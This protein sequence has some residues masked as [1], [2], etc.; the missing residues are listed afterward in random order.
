MARPE[1]SLRASEGSSA[2]EFAYADVTGHDVR[3]RHLGTGELR[4]LHPSPD[5]EAP[6]GPSRVPTAVVRHVRSDWALAT[7]D[8]TL[9]A[10]SWLTA[11]V[12]KFDA[13]GLDQAWELSWP[14]LPLVVLVTLSLHAAVGLYSGVWRHAS[15]HEARRVVVAHLLTLAIAV[16]AVVLLGRR[17]G[18]AVPFIATGLA[19]GLV[20][21][22]RF[23]SRLFAFRRRQARDAT[24]LIVLGAGS[25]GASLARD[26][27]QHDEAM[28]TA[29][30]DDDPALNGRRVQRITVQGTLADLPAVARRTGATHAVLAIPSAS[31]E[32]V[33]RVA[34][35][36]EDA[37]VVLRVVPPVSELVNG[38]VVLR[39]VRDLEIS[40]LLSRAPVETD[41]EDVLGLVRGRRVLVTGGGGSIGSEIARQVAHLGAARVVLV[42][43]DET[44]LF[45]TAAGLPDSA[46]LRL[47]DIREPEALRRLFEDE[48]PQVV[49][50]AAAHKHVP[51]LETHPVE[52]A[53]T[54]VLGTQSVV[55]AAHRAGVER[56]VF[57]S[58][59]KAVRPKSLMG[60]T[61]LVGERV[62]LS[63]DNAMTC[64]AVRFGNVLGS[65]G[66]VV[67]TFVQ[68]IRT[69]GPVTI[70]DPRMTRYF[71]SIPEAVRLVLHAAALSRG[72]EIFMLD[73]GDPVSVMDL[74][75]RMI[76]LSG[77]R[78]GHDIEVRV[79][80]IRPGEKLNEQLHA[81]EEKTHT[82]SHP[83]IVRLDPVPVGVAAL[84]RLL[85]ELAAAA[86]RRDDV[87]V[88]AILRD[89]V[90]PG[91]EPR[92]PE[93]RPLEPRHARSV[94]WTLSA[95]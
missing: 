55:E 83:A 63:R 45:D 65:R 48:R 67:P 37:G 20:G 59:D 64:C 90:G 4:E 6:L 3:E 18:I 25:A 22:V 72:G 19:M 33:R 24:S 2:P 5:T 79:T 70:T 54:N 95:T 43:H 44:H 86:E 21:A 38:R 1:S 88:R 51:L 26:I 14:F 80:G 31:P 17:D 68:Q 85:L 27:E 60:S 41:L 23:Q 74:A 36:A 66:S 76:R 16:P 28:V 81:A 35:L 13:R 93:Q 56:F 29:F 92:V 34:G 73:M 62:V 61:K 40:D 15:V 77:R 11:L 49:F 87:G 50:H 30:L 84:D 94:A 39:D 46:A 42:D 78:P 10:M 82:T 9:I 32:V 47:A 89:L 12:L 71:M 91:S 75:T 57:I 7:I 52:A 69:G 8:A 53:L 58:T